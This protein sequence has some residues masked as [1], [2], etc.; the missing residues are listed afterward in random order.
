[1]SDATLSKP[2]TM[3]RA[4]WVYAA[5][6]GSFAIGLLPGPPRWFYSYLHEMGHV[7]A[8]FLTGGRGFVLSER[9]AVT[10]GGNLSVI[11]ASGVLGHVILGCA[12]AYAALRWR[13]GT[14]YA[15]GAVS[16][17]IVGLWRNV[18]GDWRHMNQATRDAVWLLRPVFLLAAL[19][20][21][22]YWFVKSV[23]R[24]ASE[25]THSR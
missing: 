10:W 4:R 5:F 16:S 11:Y 24:S 19:G 18:H 3:N 7:I 13:R 25:L 17:G 2:I 14:W 20:L 8:A 1:M 12:I 22:A 21:T 6:V 15:G 9:L 23:E